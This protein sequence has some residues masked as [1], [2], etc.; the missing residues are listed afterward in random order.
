MVEFVHEDRPG[1]DVL[2]DPNT[3]LGFPDSW[4]VGPDVG[5]VATV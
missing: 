3:H 1:P 4:L 2:K 5:V